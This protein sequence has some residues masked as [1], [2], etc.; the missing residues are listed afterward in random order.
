MGHK[1]NGSWVEA[2]Q[3]NLVPQNDGTT[4]LVIRSRNSA[5]GW[6]WDLIRPGEFIMMRGMMLGIKER[7]EAMSE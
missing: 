4:R 3:F 5:Q 2:W 7:A 1:D 6:F